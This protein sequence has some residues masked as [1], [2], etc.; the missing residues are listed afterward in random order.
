MVATCYEAE[1][2]PGPEWS[3]S[4]AALR[5]ILEVEILYTATPLRGQTRTTPR[6]ALYVSG[7]DKR[8]RVTL[9]HLVIVDKSDGRVCQVRQ[10]HDYNTIDGVP[11]ISV[12][13]R[14]M[15]RF[16][17]RIKGGEELR[18]WLEV[19]DL[20]PSKLGSD[21]LEVEYPWAVTV[22]ITDEGS[23]VLMNTG[24][25]KIFVMEYSAN[26]WTERTLFELLPAKE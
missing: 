4:K 18:N 23:V 3:L 1:L 24:G 20:T 26:G 11:V 2:N 5:D 7:L 10:F 9:R 21:P 13:G 12:N 17:D 22:A 15:G 6:L 25:E 16:V 19:S 14:W 8:N